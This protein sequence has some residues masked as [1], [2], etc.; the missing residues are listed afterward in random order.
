MAQLL[1][2]PATMGSATAEA[3][4]KQFAEARTFCAH[5]VYQP[6][7]AYFAADPNTWVGAVRA[8]PGAAATT[9]SSCAAAIEALLAGSSR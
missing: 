4:A 7:E 3:L 6:K 9:T 1:A 2:Q 8:T 5:M